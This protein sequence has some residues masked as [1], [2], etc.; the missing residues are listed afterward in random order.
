MQNFSEQKSDAH[1]TKHDIKRQCPRL[2]VA[3][4]QRRGKCMV[5]LIGAAFMLLCLAPL[6]TRDPHRTSR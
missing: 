2:R 1:E 3:T 4:I 5:E 6:L